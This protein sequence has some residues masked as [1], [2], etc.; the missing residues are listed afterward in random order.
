MEL[1]DYFMFNK[2][3]PN[4]HLQKQKNPKI[5]YDPP[6]NSI[7][8]KKICFHNLYLLCLQLQQ[9]NEIVYIS[10]SYQ[11]KNAHTVHPEYY[12]YITDRHILQC[13]MEGV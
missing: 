3:I 1:C 9:E 2:S 12:I 6:K 8:P 4:Y 13:I 11:L 10:C 7:T 5:K